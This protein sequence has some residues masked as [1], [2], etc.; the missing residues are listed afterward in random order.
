MT[1]NLCFCSTDLKL[2][3]RQFDQVFVYFKYD[4]V[5]VLLKRSPTLT[6]PQSHT[7]LTWEEPIHYAWLELIDSVIKVFVGADPLCMD[8][9]SSFVVLRTNWR[10]VVNIPRLVNLW[11]LNFD[12][13]LDLIAKVHSEYQ[14]V[15]CPGFIP[16]APP[17]P[18]E[19]QAIIKIRRNTMY[20]ERMNI[21]KIGRIEITTECL[22]RLFASR[23]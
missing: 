1:L 19:W 10:T 14:E 9:V 6:V 18:S 20:E 3:Y 4:R 12:F 7:G 21:I 15:K 8:R 5:I 2:T 17:S 23:K 13:D 16:I 11:V 22:Y